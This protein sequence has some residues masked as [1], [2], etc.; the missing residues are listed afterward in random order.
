[1]RKYATAAIILAAS[2]MGAVAQSTSP[3]S[4]D[5]RANI[6]PQTHCRDKDGNVWLRSSAQLAGSTDKAAN[7][8][9]NAAASAD[10]SFRSS[11]PVA[12]SGGRDM[13]EVARSLPDCP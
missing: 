8:E 10:S 7:T 13:T 4:S 5:N 12:R 6:T 1:M 3:P 2:V 11:A 9:T